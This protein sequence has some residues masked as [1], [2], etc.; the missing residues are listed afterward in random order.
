MGP[1]RVGLAFNIEIWGAGGWLGRRKTFSAYRWEFGT[2]G[3]T[4][5]PMSHGM[6][7]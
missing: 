7:K 3:L 1:R 4:P 5:V 2:G 6:S